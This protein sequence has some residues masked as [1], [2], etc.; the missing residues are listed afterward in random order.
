MPGDL[1]EK[2][3]SLKGR[4]QKAG[5]FNMSIH[6]VVTAVIYHAL[7]G[8]AGA[9]LPSKFWLKFCLSVKGV[10]LA[11]T[12]A[13]DASGGCGVARRPVCLEQKDSG[14]RRGGHGTGCIRVGDPSRHPSHCGEESLLQALNEAPVPNQSPELAGVWERAGRCVCRGARVSHVLQLKIL[15]KVL[16]STYHVSPYILFIYF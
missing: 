7:N 15:E 14:T 3:L 13:L 1:R 8:S 16:C 6:V 9:T 2:K 11:L 5:L 12:A 4:R 10:G